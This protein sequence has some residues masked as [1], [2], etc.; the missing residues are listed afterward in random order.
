MCKELPFWDRNIGSWETIL[1]GNKQ[2]NKEPL[3]YILVRIKKKKRKE[4][5][6]SREKIIE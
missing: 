4:E 5:R 2:W 1:A 6:K 3:P